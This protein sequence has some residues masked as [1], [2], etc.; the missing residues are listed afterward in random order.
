MAEPTT[1]YCSETLLDRFMSSGFSTAAADNNADGTADTDVINDALMDATLE[2]WT[3]CCGTYS[4]EGLEAS[5]RVETW[6]KILGAYNLSMT[7]GNPPPDAWA[8][9]VEKIRETLDKIAGGTLLLPGVSLRGDMR[10]T[11]S[12][13]RI[14]RRFPNSTVRV[15]PT[16]SSSPAT[17]LTR[18]A[19][20]DYP[21]A[22]D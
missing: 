19:V 3:A 6:C 1:P 14:D 9:E 17:T 22:Y 21:A 8:M 13:L 15:T 11:L 12:N 5:T 4:D 16:N 7:R 10:P 20:P 2:I 18:D